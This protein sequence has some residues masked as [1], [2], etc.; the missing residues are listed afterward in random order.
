MSD[1][2][3]GEL[4]YPSRLLGRNV[5]LHSGEWSDTLPGRATRELY[6]TPGTARG[7]L[8]GD[9]LADAVVVLFTDPGASGKFIDLV[10]VVAGGGR[11]GSPLTAKVGKPSTLGDRVVA[12]SLWIDHQRLFLRLLNQAEDDPLCCP[13]QLEQ[14]TYRLDRD[15]LRLEGTTTLRRVPHEADSVLR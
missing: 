12:E 10:P 5:R 14:R 3:L 13:T 9:D 2:L 1:S 15:S 8:T 11:G 7:D 4:S 6:I